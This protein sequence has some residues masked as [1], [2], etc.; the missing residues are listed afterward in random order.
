MGPING[1]MSIAPIITAVEFIFNP[2]E[3]TKIANIK[4]HKLVP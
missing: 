3:A 1:E 4:I 2:T